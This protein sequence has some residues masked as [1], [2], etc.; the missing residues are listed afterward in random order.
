VGLKTIQGL[1]KLVYLD[2]QGCVKIS[3]GGVSK[4]RRRTL[5]IHK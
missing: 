1:R 3:N 5:T 2:L 4:L